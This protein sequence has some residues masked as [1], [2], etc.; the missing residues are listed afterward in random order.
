MK[1]GVTRKIR[2][3]IITV[4]SLVLLLFITSLLAINIPYVNYSRYEETVPLHPQVKHI[5][6]GET[7]KLYSVVL[8]SLDNK[9]INCYLK[10]PKT[11][12]PYPAIAFFDGFDQGKEV[13]DY[14]DDSWWKVGWAAIAMDYRYS[15]STSNKALIFLQGRRATH[16]AILDIRRMIE[17]L[18]SRDDIDSTRIAVM[19]TSLG[20]IL[21]PPV[22]AN[23]PRVKAVVMI[24]GGGDVGLIAANQFEVNRF[25]KRLIRYAARVYYSPFEPL[26]YVKNISPTPSL[27]IIAEDDELI[28]MESARRLAETAREPKEIIL[29]RV[30]HLYPGT[31]PQ[32]DSILTVA[33]PWI[34]DVMMGN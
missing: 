33:V 32:I 13:I 2:L 27:F 9:N 18:Y 1:T 28:P 31:T 6:T 22:A 17:Y 8:N 19:A 5:R 12:P 16:E 21:A 4:V 23:N 29:E 15:P 30:E 3:S 10:L 26:K 24:Q 14:V 34:Q 11:H 20:A 7:Y 25:L